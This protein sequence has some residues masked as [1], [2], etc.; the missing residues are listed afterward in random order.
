MGDG[1]GRGTDA[2]GVGA[3]SAEAGG[4]KP[5]RSP[6]L[7]AGGASDADRSGA[8]KAKAAKK[9]SA[10]NANPEATLATTRHADQ[11][12]RPRLSTGA[13]AGNVTRFGDGTPTL[14]RQSAPTRRSRSSISE[15]MWSF[16][17]PAPS[18]P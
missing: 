18:C 1:V 4:E 5:I 16:M 12:D 8:G 15:S 6:V 3:A 13:F 9:T 17:T 11:F 10:I 7:L 14:R 2:G